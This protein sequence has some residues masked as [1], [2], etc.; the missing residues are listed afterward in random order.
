MT[1]EE[2]VARRAEVR[3][4]LADVEAE[5]TARTREE[6]LRHQ[7]ALDEAH[8][9]HRDNLTQIEAEARTKRLALREEFDRLGQAMRPVCPMDATAN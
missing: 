9:T 6:W 2:I 3:Q 5:K 8:N 1:N 4:Q 7:K